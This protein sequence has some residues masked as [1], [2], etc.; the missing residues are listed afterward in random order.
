MNASAYISPSPLTTL[1]APGASIPVV[2]AKGLPTGESAILPPFNI[3]V[4]KRAGT[5]SLTAVQPIYA[6][7]RITNTNKL[8]DLGIDVAR[9][10]ATVARRDAV[11]AAEE[12]YW[13]ILDLR[14]R[15]RTLTAYQAMLTQLQKQADDA[16]TSGFATRSDS[17]DVSVKRRDAEVDR[18]R[19]E[20]A[21]RLTARDLRRHLGLPEGDSLALAD[22]LAE[23]AEI[24]A[25][26][27]DRDAGT[28]RRPEVRQ[29][30]RG[31]RAAELETEL[32]RADMLPTVS[33]GAT[34]QY[35]AM[36][37]A[38][39]YHD[40][41][42]FA[43]LS[44]PLTGIW[45]G[46]HTT[47]AQ[48][49]KKREAEIRLADGR[50]QVRIE[51]EKRWDNL[52]ASVRAVSAGRLAVD[53]AQVKLREKTDQWQ[54]GLSDFSDMLEAEVLLHRAQDRLTDA[55]TQYWLD[56]TAYQRAIGGE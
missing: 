24:A 18:L 13:R 6:G 14:E 19:L 56:R 25:S 45:E 47:R 9:D 44:I 32:K 39:T 4:G 8:A 40:V 33:V 10:N 2:N 37:G 46:S 38:S 48:N 31:V 42:G 34:A 36:S 26:L 52:T 3:E 11:A 49:E 55:R 21:I 51:I 27:A 20:S 43:T 22:D 29:L 50:E 41:L 23:P 12:M 15:E 53:Q 16:V 54:N 5:V 7:G 28:D 30:R 1:A 17:L 35:L